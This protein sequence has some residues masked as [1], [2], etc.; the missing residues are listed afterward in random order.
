MAAIWKGSISF[1]LVNI[2]V[3][4]H[5]AV[6]DDH[7]AFRMLEKDTLSP[8]NYERVSKKTGK[9]VPWAKIVKGFEYTKGK[10][11]VI[12]DEDF[13]KAA[14]GTSKAFEIEDFVPESQID[15]RFFEKPYYVVPEGGSDSVYALLR[16][17]MIE[18]EMVG[19]GRLTIRQK[20][21]LAAVKPLGNALEINLMRFADEIIS[22][23]EYEIPKKEKPKPAALKMAKQLISSLSKDFEPE[24]YRD[25]YRLNLEKLIKSK[26]KGK[27][28]EF[29]EPQER[30][31]TGLSDLM[32]RL[33]ESLGK[34]PTPQAQVAAR[35]GSGSSSKSKA[36]SKA[37]TSTKTKT[38]RKSKA[39][40][41]TRKRA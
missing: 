33:Q 18:T 26:T 6:R 17:A 16:E 11:V 7:I 38:T 41:K 29:D 37:K 8:I 20:Q 34:R 40:K 14:T 24:Q 30:K 31:A 39:S 15:P 12:S 2:P 27:E 4:L 32:E 21:H 25:E 1:G 5:S 10:F 19:I 35:K 22:E 13:Q 9:T 3:S 28:I 36:K 23:K